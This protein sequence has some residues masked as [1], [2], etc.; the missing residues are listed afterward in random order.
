MPHFPP[1]AARRTVQPPF[2][3]AVAG[4]T[5]EQVKLAM[6]GGPTIFDKE[7]ADDV[8][9]YVRK[10][11]VM[12]NTSGDVGYI[13]SS[14]LGSGE[15]MSRGPVFTSGSE[16]EVRTTIFFKGDRATNARTL[17]ERQ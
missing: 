1:A 7:G 17:R 9:I 3:D 16:A 6:G 8:W 2:T 15:N 5:K 14:S 13:A 11:S 12:T 4:L 10:E